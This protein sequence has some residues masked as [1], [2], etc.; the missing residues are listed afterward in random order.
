MIARSTG[1][2]FAALAAFASSFGLPAAAATVAPPPS[3]GF[4]L[5]RDGGELWLLSPEGARAA[6]LSPTLRVTPR[7]GHEQTATAASWTRDGDGYV[8][9]VDMRGVRWSLRVDG[10]GVRATATTTSTSPLSSVAL[11]VRVSSS[12][13]QVL[14]RAYRFGPAPVRVDRW[15]PQVARFDRMTVLGSAQGM[16]VAKDGDGYTVRLD[17]DDARAHPFVRQSACTDDMWRTTGSTDVG[18]APPPRGTTTTVLLKYFVDAPPLP[19]ALRWPAGRRAALVFTDHA[20]QSSAL[21]LGALMYGS[22]TKGAPY[23]APG[24]RR[25]M[26]GHGL[27]MTKSVFALHH[28]YYP[29][30]LD[31]PRF[32]DVVDR[33]AKAGVDVAV[34][35]VSGGPDTPETTA[36]TLPQYAKWS[37]STWID[38]QPTTNCEALSNR[39]AV[40]GPW[41][42]VDVLHDGGFRYA[43]SGVDLRSDQLNLWAPARRD[44]FAPLLFQHPDTRGLWLFVSQWMAFPRRVFLDRYDDGAL[45]RLVAERG[46]HVAHSYLDIH[47]ISGTPLDAWALLDKVPGG[48]RLSD[49]ADALF[50]RLQRRQEEGDLWVTTLPQL[51]ERLQ[52]VAGVDLD[53][54]AGRDGAELVVRA[55]TPVPSLSLLMPDGSVRIVDVGEDALRLPWPAGGGTPVRLP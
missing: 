47:V 33:V 27:T 1:L 53:V 44:D 15:T 49:D 25:G 7:S 46:V 32:V 28:H 9:G 8:A 4:T 19:V 39:G 34:H 6:R 38:H 54:Q 50:A 29:A 52:A 41:Y 48:F 10:H 12:T 18:D 26:L 45:D 17:V 21:R 42:I 55:P 5:V 20:D 35:S 14:D 3:T 51:A 13:A 31:D 16:R 11:E 23:G 43:W 36:A 40:P 24:E 30:Q 2:A 37:P 22:S